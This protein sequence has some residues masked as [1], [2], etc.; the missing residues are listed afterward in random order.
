MLLYVCIKNMC[1]QNMKIKFKF[2][3]FYSNKYLYRMYKLF[4]SIILKNKID[5]TESKNH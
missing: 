4:V 1:N 2:F 5:K 3:F